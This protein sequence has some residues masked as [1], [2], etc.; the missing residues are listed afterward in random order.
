MPL[1]VAIYD[2]NARLSQFANKT[3]HVRYFDATAFLCPK[4]MCSAYDGNGN[5]MYF[6]EEHLTMAASWEL[7]KEILLVDGVP[8][9]FRQRVVQ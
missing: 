2:M 3:A 6:D 8:E 1:S 5:P 7:G 9:P 4:G